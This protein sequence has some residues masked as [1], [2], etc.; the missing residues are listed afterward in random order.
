MYITL[1]AWVFDLASNEWIQFLLSCCERSNELTRI[2]S[3]T[4]NRFSAL[5][6][7]SLS[8]SFDLELIN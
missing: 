8:L 6:S 3:K 2:L 1:G 7:L 4:E 5:L